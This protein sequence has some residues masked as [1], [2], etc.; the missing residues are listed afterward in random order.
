MEL[1]TIQ[2]HQLNRF[3]VKSLKKLCDVEKVI[4]TKH[5]M[6]HISKIWY[7]L[8]IRI[9]TL[10]LTCSLNDSFS[11]YVWWLKFLWHFNK[12]SL[13]KCDKKNSKAMN[14]KYNRC[15][16]NNYSNHEKIICCNWFHSSNIKKKNSITEKISQWQI[17]IILN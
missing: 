17:H 1:C 11:T 13:E 9:M 12:V 6:T 8:F 14:F 7:Y 5:N 16:S 4:S 15:I 3:L 10:S 2:S